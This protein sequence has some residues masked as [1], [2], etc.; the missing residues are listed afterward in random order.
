MPPAPPNRPNAAAFHY[1]TYSYPGDALAGPFQLSGGP[2]PVG[3]Q[4]YSLV[5]DLNG[6][7]AWG[8]PN[9]VPN[10]AV[11]PVPGGAPTLGGRNT[12]MLTLG[13]APGVVNAPAVI[14]TGGIHAREWIAAEFVYLLAEYLVRHYPAPANRF[15]RTIRSLVDSRRIFIIPMLN[16]DGNIFTVFNPAPV[17]RL[18]RKNRNPLPATPVA[19]VN[20]LTNGGLLGPNPPP[21]QNVQVPVGLGALATYD[22]P[23]YDPDNGIPP[24][25]AVRPTR[26][27][28]NNQTG[29]DANRN[30]STLAWGYDGMRQTAA[31]PVPTQSFNPFHD[32]YFGPATGS[33]TETSNLQIAFT[34]AHPGIATMIDYHSYAQAI[35]YPSETFNNGGVGPD[36]SVLGMTL[37][38]LVHT[39]GALDYQLGSP[40]QIISYDAPGT[41]IDR[42]AQQH[43]ARAFTIELDPALGT[44]NGFVLNENQICNVFEKNIRGALAALAA[45]ARP[46]HWFTAYLQG[47]P[48][49][50]NMLKFMTWNVYGRGNQ[51]P[52]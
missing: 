47:L 9:G 41:V 25:P 7:V 34:W 37:R 49:G 22:S 2:L 33:E 36:Y 6:L 50:W 46:G 11:A 12:L 19:W 45:P 3:S 13:P 44:A 16:P 21:F 39:Q 14:I 15:Q 43:Q 24:G 40:R 29:V 17:G 20:L 52:L 28:A 18:W 51:L 31:G 27:L 35:L 1:H 32:G 26:Q 30:F 10:L 23:I 5:E 38:Q 8:V 4:L 48:L 42:A